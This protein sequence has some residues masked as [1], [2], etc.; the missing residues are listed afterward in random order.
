MSEMIKA[1]RAVKARGEGNGNPVLTET[2]A[3]EIR[4]LCIEGQLS[5]REI[6]VMYGVSR[7]L[8]YQIAAGKRWAHVEPRE[9]AWEPLPVAGI[10]RRL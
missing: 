2:E 5:Q 4:F 6:A 7:G 1:G 9:P 10:R 3:R 8:V